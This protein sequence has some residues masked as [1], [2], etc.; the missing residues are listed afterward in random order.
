MSYKKILKITIVT[1]LISITLV[2]IDVINIFLNSSSNGVQLGDEK[3]YIPFNNNETNTED[4]LTN[5][6]CEDVDDSQIDGDIYLSELEPIDG[7]FDISQETAKDVYDNEYDEYFNIFLNE[8]GFEEVSAEYAING[9]YSLLTGTLF[10]AR[11]EGIRSAYKMEIYVDDSKVYTSS[12][13]KLKTKPKKFKIPISDANFIKIVFYFIDGNSE[14][15][16]DGFIGNT[17][18]C[19][20][21]AKLT[22]Q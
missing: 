4:N 17:H 10:T 3:D 5:D 9:K 11:D 14:G 13:I 7:E 2:H 12:K 21:D 16:V 8:L 19:L 22:Q 15:A 6:Y 20:Y 18:A 1:T